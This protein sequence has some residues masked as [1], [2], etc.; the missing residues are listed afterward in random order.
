MVGAE[1]VEPSFDP[2][3]ESVLTVELRPDSKVDSAGLEPTTN[4]LKGGYSDH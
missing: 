1:G 2:Y 4:R 3:K